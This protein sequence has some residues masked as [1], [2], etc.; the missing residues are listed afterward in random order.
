MAQNAYFFLCGQFK[1]ALKKS[2]FNAVVSLFFIGSER[3]ASIFII[4]PKVV[5][6]GWV[7][8]PLG[9]YADAEEK[10]GLSL[11]DNGLLR[12]ST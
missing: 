7:S 11:L 4:I 6:E 12:P 2:T 8:W 9:C 3:S 5:L 1:K 10:Y